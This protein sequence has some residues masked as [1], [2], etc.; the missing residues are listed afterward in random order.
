MAE[1]R[2]KAQTSGTRKEKQAVTLLPPR[3]DS[4]AVPRRAPPELLVENQ[5]S[6]M[7]L[8]PGLGKMRLAQIHAEKP[9]EFQLPG[10]PEADLGTPFADDL[11]G[12]FGRADVFGLIV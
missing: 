10:D 1:P 5:D 2:S 6:N 7:P 12:T 9:L 3:E 4:P 8:R 11:P